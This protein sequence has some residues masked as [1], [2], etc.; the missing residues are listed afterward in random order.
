MNVATFPSQEVYMGRPIAGFYAHGDKRSTLLL[1]DAVP[2]SRYF[3]F[4]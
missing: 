4:P 3:Y 1:P 2:P